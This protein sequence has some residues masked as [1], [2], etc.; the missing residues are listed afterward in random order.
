M[1]REK[2][3]KDTDNENEK[4]EEEEMLE[5]ALYNFTTWFANSLRDEAI[6]KIYKNLTAIFS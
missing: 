3:K 5:E 6:Y 4:E 1:E 2:R